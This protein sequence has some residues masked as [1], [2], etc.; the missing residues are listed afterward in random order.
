[1]LFWVSF[2]TVP[3]GLI[4]LAHLVSIFSV[5]GQNYWVFEDLMNATSVK[6]HRSSCGN[7]TRSERT[8]TTRWHGPYDLETA[9]S[10]AKRLSRSKGWDYAK[11]CM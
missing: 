4:C 10:V 3:M 7:V 8:S 9:E 1:M 5:E 2:L 11:C 6:I